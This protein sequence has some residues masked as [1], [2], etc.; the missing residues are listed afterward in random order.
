MGENSEKPANA[1][2]YKRILSSLVLGPLA[3]T[4]ILKGGFYFAGM[5]A[6]I[7]I[8]SFCEWLGMAKASPHRYR[9][10][11]AG[12]FYLTFCLV[13]YVFLRFDAA[14]GAWLT[15][16]IMLAVWASDTGAYFTGK[17]IGGPKLA[18]AISPNKTW[19]G[20]GGAM[21][22]CGLMMALLVV[23]GHSIPPKM[24]VTDLGLKPGYIPYVFFIGCFL[25][26]VGQAGDLFIS[27]FKRRSGLKDTGHLIP[28]HGGLLDRIDSLLLVSPIFLAITMLWLK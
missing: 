3:V 28:G 4:L 21:F 17:M 13:A 18:P 8:I 25:G 26:A 15:L 27:W 11:I 22:F 24:L 5:V 20:L 10:L 16:G 23:L 12:S 19:A 2:L 14:Q 9:D 7:T 1:T 6:I